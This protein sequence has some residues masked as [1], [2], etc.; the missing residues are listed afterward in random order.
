M[1][2]NILKIAAASRYHCTLLRGAVRKVTASGSP[3]TAADTPTEVPPNLGTVLLLQ[4]VVS[5]QH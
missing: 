3:Q 5:I 4:L 1:Y 2:C